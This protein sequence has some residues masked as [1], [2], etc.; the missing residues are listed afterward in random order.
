M[1]LGYVVKNNSEIEKNSLG[2]QSRMG[3]TDKYRISHTKKRAWQ[4][5][6]K[7]SLGK[8]KMTW[9]LYIHFLGI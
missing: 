6:E 4:M 2:T 1:W 3:E 5:R 7:K 8:L 9:V